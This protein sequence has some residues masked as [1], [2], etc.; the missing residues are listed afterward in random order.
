ML[1]ICDASAR[2]PVACVPM[3]EMAEELHARSHFSTGTDWC[4]TVCLLITRLGVR[5]QLIIIR[6]IDGATAF[7]SVS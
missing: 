6:T 1:L 5:R 2:D 3:G 4:M 7:L